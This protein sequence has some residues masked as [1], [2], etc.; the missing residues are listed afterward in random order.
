VKTIVEN[1][2]NF[3]IT[4]ATIHISVSLLH[5][6]SDRVLFSFV[7]VV[8]V[9]IVIIIVVACGGVV[10]A[11]MICLITSPGLTN[12][13]LFYPLLY[14]VSLPESYEPHILYE[15]KRR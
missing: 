3:L 4:R 7:T 15:I 13:F 8:V 14:F 1:V 5:G 10:M 11:L 2:L 6:F 12:S 9:I